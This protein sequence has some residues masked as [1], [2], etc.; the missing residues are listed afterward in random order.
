MRPWEIA[1]AAVFLVFC[2]VAGLVL[3]NNIAPAPTVGVV[4]F[5]GELDTRAANA[6]AS[7]IESARQDASVSAVVLEILS[8]GG[9]ATSSESTFYSLLRLREQKPLV[10]VVD[11]LAA[12]GGYYLA[13][14]GDRIF[15]PA[16]AFVGNVGTRGGRPSDP[17]IAPDE[18]STGPYK[19]EGGSRFDQIHQ[20]QLSAD[21]FVKNVVAQRAASPVNPLKL[22]PD[23]LAEA[24]IYLGSE[25]LAVGLIDAEGGRTEGI[26]EAAKLAGIGDYQVIDLAAAYG[27][28]PA[29]GAP[30]DRLQ[31]MVRTAPPGAIFMLDIRISLPEETGSPSSTDLSSKR[32]RDAALAP[33]ARA[34]TWLDRLPQLSAP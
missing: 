10:V 29:T 28:G 33:N 31:Q 19:L 15:A 5:E 26:Q 16:S 32:S 24:R 8:P 9:F 17:T 3:G 20:L 30:T 11:S 34:G 2:L 27:F 13:A 7:L 25:A 4:R 18:L 6:L 21:S 1:L 12:S 23:E 22:T 14:A